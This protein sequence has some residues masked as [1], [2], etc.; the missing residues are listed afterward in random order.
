L[1]LD[2]ILPWNQHGT[3]EL[4]SKGTI[5]NSFKFQRRPGDP[6]QQYAGAASNIG[7]FAGTLPK[8]RF[9]STVDWSYQNLDITLANTFIDSVQD[10]GAAG[11]LP[12]ISV[13]SYSTWDLRGT[14]TWMLGSEDSDKSLELALGVNN[15]SNKMPPIFPRSFTNQFTTSDIGTYSPIGRLVYGSVRVSF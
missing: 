15:I 4:S 7:V 12:G 1:G 8:Y 9:Y 3:W 11:T 5:F 14:Y 10:E 6:S 2:Y 13:P